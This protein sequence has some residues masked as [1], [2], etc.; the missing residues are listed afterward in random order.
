MQ[1]GTPERKRKVTLNKS[2]SNS[3]QNHNFNAMN[4]I[5]MGIGNPPSGTVQVTERVLD[6]IDLETY[7]QLLR[8][9]SSPLVGVISN[10]ENNESIQGNQ[11]HNGK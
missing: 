9:F 5:Q 11:S 1:Q 4:K 3:N 7:T 8:C 10:D 6:G 2:N